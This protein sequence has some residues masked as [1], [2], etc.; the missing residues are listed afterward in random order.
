MIQ[1]TKICIKCRR[2]KPIAMFGDKEWMIAGRQMCNSCGAMR[3]H[4]RLRLEFLD[5]FGCKC[6]CCGETH[7]YFL[8]LEHIESQH[9]KKNK[10]KT[11]RAAEIRKA[12]RE[13]WDRT[14]WDCLCIACNFA[15]GLYE[16]ARM[17]LQKDEKQL[18]LVQ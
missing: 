7:P 4:D 15:K 13:G 10:I 17:I 9:Y 14:K 12:K 3:M 18:G 2:E 11:Y 5:E 6:S 1:K 8:T 16:R